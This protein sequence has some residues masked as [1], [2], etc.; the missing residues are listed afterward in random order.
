MGT[1]GH[2]NRR[3]VAW[4]VVLAFVLDFLFFTGFFASDDAGYLTGARAIAGQGEFEAGLG[5][6]RFGITLPSALVYRLTHSV[7][8]VAW[9]HCVYHLIL[10]VLAN[11]LGRLLHG[12]RTGLIAAALIAICPLLYGFAGAV[13][14]DNAC[15]VWL[16]ASMI[17]LTL[18]QQR[19]PAAE[20]ATLT[21]WH[22]RRARGHFVAGVFLG[23]A[24]ICKESALIMTIPAAI[25][26]MSACR[27]RSLVWIQNGAFLALGLVA[28]FAADLV[29]L[30]LVSGQWV[31]KMGMISDA[32]DIYLERMSWQGD[33][34]F[35]R[36]EFA[37]D[38]LALWMPAMLWVL[39]VGSVLYA[40]WRDRHL[41]LMAFFWWPVIYLTIGTT[42]LTEWL[43]SS[44][45][46]RY[47]AIVILPAVLMTAAIVSHL[48]DRWQASER[49]P[50]WSRDRWPVAVVVFAIAV[51]GWGE[52]RAAQPNAGKIFKAPDARAFMAAIEA[53]RDNYASYPITIVPE[54]RRRMAPL[55][56]DIP[57]DPRLR[58]ED[59]KPVPPYVTIVP[60]H[61]VE[62]A[63]AAL[64]ATD[65]ARMLERLYPP[66]SRSEVLV[67]AARRMFGI[68]PK[69]PL[70]IAR[71]NRRGA[72][73]VLVTR[74]GPDRK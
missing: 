48:V 69:P 66:E 60:A 45:Q 55:L 36:F 16:A 41:G 31:S 35:E 33:S 51:L 39:L 14:P 24:Y 40:C 22:A 43:P 38:K 10:V 46:N 30:R 1:P 59:G 19:H 3:I 50:G 13:L 65:R 12:E 34:P 21:T 6:T 26:V 53:A 4:L 47:Y 37:Y 57:P 67:D 15:S 18:V 9:F 70:E 23:I 20:S 56:F 71:S 74:R 8:A 11:I 5:N 2:R 32:E 28:V 25:Y 27:L 62:A 44:I 29:M 63:V 54:Y 42:S 68:T 58:L 61:K 17:A 64:P 49:V 72:A 73:L 7:A 52:M